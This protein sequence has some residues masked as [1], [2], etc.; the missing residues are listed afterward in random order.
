MSL[1][2]LMLLRMLER[3][4]MLLLPPSAG[5]VGATEDLRVPDAPVEESDNSPLVVSNDWSVWAPG[6]TFEVDC[7]GT[8]GDGALINWGAHLWARMRELHQR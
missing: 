6:V 7:I 2:W 5:A 3:S 8:G 4:K 1:N